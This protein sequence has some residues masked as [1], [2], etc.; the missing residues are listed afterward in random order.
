M[1]YAN[2]FGWFIERVRRGNRLLGKFI[3]DWKEKT[4]TYEELAQILREERVPE[5]DDGYSGGHN[6]GINL[7]MFRFGVLLPDDEQEAEFYGEAQG[8]V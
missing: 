5:T 1:S 7:V 8:E 4:I 2:I 6:N 3:L